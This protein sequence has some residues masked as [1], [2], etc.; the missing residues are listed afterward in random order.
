MRIRI[1]YH[2]HCFDGAASAAL[3][4]R[5]LQDY[6]YPEAQ[7]LFRG[8]LH[9][10][11]FQWLPD[12]LD[13]DEN[14]I[15]DFR[16]CR[17][18]RLSW[19]FDHHLSAFLSREDEA[20]YRQNP[21]K[22]KLL[23]VR[24]TS[25]TMLIADYLHRECQYSADGLEEL[26]H[27]ADVIDGAKYPTPEAAIDV[28]SAAARLRLVLENA[29]DENL[30]QRLV[31]NLRYRSI[32]E[33]L[34][35]SAIRTL[36]QRY[37]SEALANAE[38]FAKR[39]ERRDGVGYLDLRAWPGVRFNKFLPYCICR[40]IDYALTVL[41]TEGWF[42]ISLGTNPWRGIDKPINLAEVAER[43]GGGGHSTVAGISIPIS[44]GGLLDKVVN[45]LLLQL[46]AR[47]R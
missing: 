11:R 45:Q 43:Y 30:R 23:D 21:S 19:W 42:K 2:D 41:S 47:S 36:E 28:G 33:V 7:F 6:Y 35:D 17:D 37:S 4:G 32:E 25:C 22:C 18:P 15:V 8:V 40:D 29:Q 9:R 16:Y 24:K 31:R 38:L 20:H 10:P 3:L 5:F 14:A 26:I 1:L 44:D 34:D 13:G 39:L 27:W 12:D 46:T